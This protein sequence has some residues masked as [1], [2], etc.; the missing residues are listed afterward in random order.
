M[1]ICWEMTEKSAEIMH[2]KNVY[3]I[4]TDNNQTDNDITGYGLCNFTTLQRYK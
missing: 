3:Y 2:Y 1:T 4:A